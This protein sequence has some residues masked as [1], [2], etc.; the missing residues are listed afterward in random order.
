MKSVPR[1][2]VLYR[3]IMLSGCDDVWLACGSYMDG[4]RRAGGCGVVGVLVCG[5]QV[6]RGSAWGA[7]RAYK[8]RPYIWD[9]DHVSVSPSY[10]R[11]VDHYALIIVFGGDGVFVHTSRIHHLIPWMEP[12]SDPAFWIFGN[13]TTGKTQCTF[14]T[15]NDVIVTFLPGELGDCRVSAYEIGSGTLIEINNFAQR[16]LLRFPWLV[17]PKVLGQKNN[18]MNMIGHDHKPIHVQTWEP[19]GK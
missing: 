11:D 5:R 15:R 19:T 18:P 8:S 16:R 7:R 6:A 9:T 13:I 10:I 1:A 12:I 4:M 14:I 2:P 3:H 17:V